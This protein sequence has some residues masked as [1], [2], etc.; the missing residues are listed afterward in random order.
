MKCTIIKCCCEINCMKIIKLVENH[1]TNNNNNKESDW[2]KAILQR[3]YR[4]QILQLLRQQHQQQQQLLQQSN[5]EIQR[6]RNC[7]HQFKRPQRSRRHQRKVKQQSIIRWKIAENRVIEQNLTNL[8][9]HTE[10]IICVDS[11]NS[12]KLF[13]R[14]VV[15][16][17]F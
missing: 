12:S 8:D 1:I 7:P 6:H 2:I 10:W 5:Q 15:L 13:S 16:F 11:S 9:V 17:N 4:S 3:N 14:L